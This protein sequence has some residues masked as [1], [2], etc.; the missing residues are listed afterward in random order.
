MGKY[1]PTL[2]SIERVITMNIYQD[3]HSR[4]KAAPISHEHNRHHI[5]PGSQVNLEL[6]RFLIIAITQPKN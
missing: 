3:V 4:A 1:G 6:E 2:Q 5:A